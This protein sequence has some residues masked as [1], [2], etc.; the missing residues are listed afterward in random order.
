MNYKSARTMIL[1]L[2]YFG[3]DPTIMFGNYN[4]KLGTAIAAY[5]RYG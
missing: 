5:L 4:A 1:F 3:L 2:V